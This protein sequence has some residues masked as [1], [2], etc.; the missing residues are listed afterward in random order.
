MSSIEAVILAIVEGFS[1]FLPISSTGHLMIT[2][3]LLSIFPSDFLTS[4]EVIIQTGAIAS[5][6]VLYGKTLIKQKE[7]IG[8]IVVASIPVAL[9][10]FIFYPIIKDVLL[11]D[12]E[13]VIWMLGIGGLLFIYF[14]YFISFSSKIQ[15]LKDI[16]YTTALGVGICQVLSLIPGVSRAA[17]TLLGGI[18]FGM[19]RKTSVEFSFLLAV[20]PIVGAGGLDLINTSPGVF[21]GMWMTLLGGIVIS[22]IVAYLT[23]K[24]FIR[25][26][27][28]HS[29]AIIGVYRIVL[30]IVLGI[31]FL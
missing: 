10:G 25:F 20:P 16:S 13:I 3:H 4:F 27:Q 19:D 31:F 24:W 30:A 9:M 17:S 14:E 22:A 21:E 26:I 28:E 1:E 6:L 23:M 18:G 5:V 29:L 11:K 12:V 7:L 8:K 15:T 2:S